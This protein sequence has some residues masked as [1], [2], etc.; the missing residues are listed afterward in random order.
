MSERSLLPAAD[1][2]RKPPPKKSL[3]GRL[4]SGEPNPVDVHVGKRL[5]LRRMLL[6]LSQEDVADALGV[7]FQQIQKYECAVNRLSAPRLWDLAGI[8]QCQVA[9]FFEGMDAE[10]DAASPRKMTGETRAT[11]QSAEDESA[12]RPE[13]IRLVRAYAAIKRPDTRRQILD[14]A[15]SLRSRPSKDEPAF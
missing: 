10:T 7:A 5:R 13:T 15:T 14:L 4:A 1:S 2:P 6:G 11:V 9:Y 12:G 8:L 3:R